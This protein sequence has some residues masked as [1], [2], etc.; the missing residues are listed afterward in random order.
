[1]NPDP[2]KCR[3]LGNIFLALHE[4]RP[5]AE[6]HMGNGM[7]SECGTVACHAGWFA[8]SQGKEHYL[9]RYNYISAANDMAIFLGLQSAAELE[10]WAGH[11]SSLWGN[12]C[13]NEIFW[14]DIAF[15]LPHHEEDT[16]PL[17][18]K[19]IGEH[20]LSVANRIEEVS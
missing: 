12:Y 5:N 20:W 14:S 4:K 2:E 17:T 16:T 9:F 3:E 15:G 13:G 1:M 7:F 11:N 18:L 8:V 19:I 6:V 10:S